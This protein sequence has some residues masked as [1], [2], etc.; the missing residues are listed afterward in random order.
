MRYCEL[1]SFYCGKDFLGMA[2]SGVHKT[3]V[4]FLIAFFAS[5]SPQWRIL[6]FRIIHET[7]P[8]V[9][10]EYLVFIWQSVSMCSLIHPCWQSASKMRFNAC[11]NKT[12]QITYVKSG[13]YQLFWVTCR[14]SVCLQRMNGRWCVYIWVYVC[15][16]ADGVG[17]QTVYA[18]G[19]W[20]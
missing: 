16:I 19:S 9:L 1:H 12:S 2:S 3:F 14:V 8:N 20:W 15:K 10:L 13:H 6:S 7:N 5:F 17:C 18:E 4:Y 11:L